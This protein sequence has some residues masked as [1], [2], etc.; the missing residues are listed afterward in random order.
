M[1][2]KPSITEVWAWTGK[3]L[4]VLVVLFFLAD[5]VDHYADGVAEDRLRRYLPSEVL[6]AATRT[7]VLLQQIYRIPTTDTLGR[8]LTINAYNHWIDSLKADV[9]TTLGPK[10]TQP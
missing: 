8:R 9:E 10:T 2:I 4:A 7:Q 3:F 6:N 1:S 5:G